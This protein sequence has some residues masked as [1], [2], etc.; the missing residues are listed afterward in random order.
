MPSRCGSFLRVANELARIE[1]TKLQ[2][3]TG[4]RDVVLGRLGSGATLEDEV[5]A[6]T[7]HSSQRSLIYL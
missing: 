1:R 3:L 7:Q 6:E 4:V 2:G 5:D